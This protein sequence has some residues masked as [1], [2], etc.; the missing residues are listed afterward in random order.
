MKSSAKDADRLL[1]LSTWLTDQTLRNAP[2]NARDFSVPYNAIFAP[3]ELKKMS[4]LKIYVM[5][6]PSRMYTCAACRTGKHCHFQ[7]VYLVLL[8]A[9]SPKVLHGVVWTT[10]VDRKCLPR[11]IFFNERYSRSFLGCH[12]LCQRRTFILIIIVIIA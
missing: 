3:L 10:T 4:Q 7:T 2:K 6:G 11:S 5:Y 9:N 1:R 8:S 12:K